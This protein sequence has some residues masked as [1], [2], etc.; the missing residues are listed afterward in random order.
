MSK[1]ANFIVICKYALLLSL[2]PAT[3]WDM[4]VFPVFPHLFFKT[5]LNKSAFRQ[6]EVLQRKQSDWS[7]NLPIAPTIMSQTTSSRQENSDIKTMILSQLFPPTSRTA[8]RNAPW[9]FI[10]YE[11]GLM[12]CSNRKGIHFFAWPDHIQSQWMWLVRCKWGKFVFLFQSCEL[13]L[14]NA[15]KLMRLTQGEH[16]LSVLREHYNSWETN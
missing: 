5:T 13:Q 4:E 12:V 8:L 1:L 15:S 11:L 6:N 10:W 3:C 9:C 14:C 16:L 2:M 7:E